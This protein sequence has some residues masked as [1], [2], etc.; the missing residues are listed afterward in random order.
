MQKQQ[1]RGNGDPTWNLKGLGV[2]QRKQLSSRDLDEEEATKGVK[3]GGKNV[4]ERG[5]N[6]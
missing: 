5:K 4:L 2:L 3:G 1:R 6:V